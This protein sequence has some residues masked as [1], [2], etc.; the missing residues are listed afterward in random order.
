MNEDSDMQFHNESVIA[1][2]TL[3]GNIVAFLILGASVIDFM[4]NSYVWYNQVMLSQYGV[5]GL[6]ILIGTIVAIIV[7][8]FLTG[9]FYFLVLRGLVQALN[10]GLDLYYNFQYEEEEVVVEKTVTE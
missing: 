4:W 7:Y 9:V 3:W 10:L 1:R 5:P 8:P 2:L 6:S